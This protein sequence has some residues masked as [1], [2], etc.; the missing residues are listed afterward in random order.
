MTITID[1]EQESDMP[2]LKMMQPVLGGKL[3]AIAW[4]GAIANECVL[5]DFVQ[6]VADGKCSYKSDIVAEAKKLNARLDE[7]EAAHA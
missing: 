3:S 7:K 1:Y 2:A 4:Y 6:S 5:R